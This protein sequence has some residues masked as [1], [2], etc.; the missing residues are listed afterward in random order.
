MYTRQDT[1]R[2]WDALQQEKDLI[3]NEGLEPVNNIDYWARRLI[4]AYV[5]GICDMPAQPSYRSA[6]Y[7]TNNILYGMPVTLRVSDHGGYSSSGY[8]N[9]HARTGISA[10]DKAIQD[11]PE[12]YV[13]SIEV[14]RD[15]SYKRSKMSTTIGEDCARI[16]LTNITTEYGLEEAISYID[17]ELFDF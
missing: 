8:K 2:A 9:A 5:A 13:I 16:V 3:T 4:N 1:N 6:Y 17:S 12:Q 11:E 15:K 10:Y 14:V 7:R